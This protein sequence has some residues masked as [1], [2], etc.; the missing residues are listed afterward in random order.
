MFHF[1]TRLFALHCVGIFQCRILTI[2]Y[3]TKDYFAED[4]NMQKM[5]NV[6]TSNLKFSL[7]NYNDPFADFIS[8]IAE[9]SSLFLAKYCDL[10]FFNCIPAY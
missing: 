3:G 1:Q 4:V 8:M 5:G 2:V 7:A 9:L 10:M 6:I